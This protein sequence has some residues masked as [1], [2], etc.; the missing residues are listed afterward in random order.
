MKHTPTLDLD[1]VRSQFPAFAEPSLQAHA[2]F[3]NAGGSYACQAVIDRLDRY[4]RQTKLQPYYPSSPSME[5]GREMD[6]SYERLASW[7]GVA[8]SEV[9]LG[10]STTQNAYVLANAAL[11]YLRAGDE[12]VVTNQEHEA[13]SGAWRRLERHDMVIREWQVNP[14]TGLLDPDDLDALLN[15]RTRL[16][17]FTH[18]SNIVGHINPVT[19]IAQKIRAAGALSVVDGVSYAAHGFPD[20]AALDVDV[21]LFSLYK[22]YGPHQGLMVLRDRAAH[23]FANQSH[24]FND[25]QPRKRLVPAGPDHAQ[26]A[27]AQGI[28]DYFDAV[29]DHHFGD[30]SG[31]RRAAVAALFAEAEKA[32]LAPLLDAL[33]AHPRVTLI[34]PDA[35]APRAPT[36]SITVKGYAAKTLCE[37]LARLNVMCGHGHFYAARLL[38]AMGI[39]SADGV[40]RLSFVHYTSDRDIERAVDALDKL[41]D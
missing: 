9:L 7:L 21:Y 4:Y 29:Y 2:F 41:L 19:T 24:Y 1:F 32:R 37:D 11:G 13:N 40:L 14:Q 31:D 18:C 38:D 23:H 25:D 22:T 34:G 33:R 8:P 20:V 30:Q 10:P 15:E 39:D 27:A 26:V 12:V 28:I 6:A 5:A 17:A 16:V 3:E 36:V 35:D